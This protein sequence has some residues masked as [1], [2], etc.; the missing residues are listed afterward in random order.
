[1]IIK[2]KYF[3]TFIFLVIWAFVSLPLLSQQVKTSLIYVVNKPAKI[4]PKTPVLIILHGYGSQETDSKEMA[5]TLS[6]RFLVF[7]L[8]A[9]HS[10]TVGGFCWFKMD[11]LPWAQF[12]NNYKEAEASKAKILSFISQAC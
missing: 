1:M 6:D 4:T 2:K 5:K 3:R 7:S 12:K 10:T 9:P 11:F 8:R